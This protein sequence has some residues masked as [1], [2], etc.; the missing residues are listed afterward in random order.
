MNDFS[1]LHTNCFEISI[2]LGCDK[3][4]HESEL[5]SEWE[6]NR[7]ALLAFIEQVIKHIQ[8]RSLCGIVAETQSQKVDGCRISI[9]REY[10]VKQRQ[11]LKKCWSCDPQV[12]RG[13]KGVVRDVEGNLLANATVSVEGIKHDVKT[14]NRH[15]VILA[16]RGLVHIEACFFTIKLKLFVARSNLAI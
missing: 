6:N 2:F 15:S 7:E 1:Y 5:A 3:F 10:E 4:P 16:L 12:H 14:G 8:I 13:I 9:S 11:S